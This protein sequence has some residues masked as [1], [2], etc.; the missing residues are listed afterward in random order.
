MNDGSAN[1]AELPTSYVNFHC[2]DI[3]LGEQL[4]DQEPSSP[5]VLTLEPQPVPFHTLILDMAGVCF[6]DLMGIKAL[7]KVIKFSP[8]LTES[9]L[10]QYR[11]NVM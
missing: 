3:E 5:P 2:N 10:I 6:I 4:P 1:N 8:V 7:I 9:G 11:I